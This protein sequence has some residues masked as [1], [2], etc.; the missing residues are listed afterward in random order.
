MAADAQSAIHGERLVQMGKGFGCVQ[1]HGIADQPPVQVFERT[2]IELL[3]ARSRLRHEYYTRWL[4]D[5][6][7]L[8]P[9][10]RMPKYADAKGRTAITD[11][12]GGDAAKQFEAIWQYLGGRQAAPR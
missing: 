9:D 4:R 8:D 1:C 5:P 12:L 7:R 6:T 10:A 2:G 11:V 3:T